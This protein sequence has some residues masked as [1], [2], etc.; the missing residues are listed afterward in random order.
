MAGAPKI[1]WVLHV[2]TR[3][4]PHRFYAQIPGWPEATMDDHGRLLA[5][6]RDRDADRTRAEMQN[7]IV[8]ADEL[9]AAHVEARAAE[10][11]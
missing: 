5:A 7:H 11:R 6:I 2:L 10:V 9:L 8:H 4:V 3:Y 1:A